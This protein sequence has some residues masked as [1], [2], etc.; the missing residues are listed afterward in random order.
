MKRFTGWFLEV[1]APS[2]QPIFLIGIIILLLATLLSILFP[3]II[4]PSWTN[5]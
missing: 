3:P 4:D 2:G 1:F 5:L